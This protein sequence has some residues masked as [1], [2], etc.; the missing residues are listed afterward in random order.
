M[1]A[2]PELVRLELLRRLR[3][4]VAFVTWTA[5][6][7]LMVGLLA[8]V[9]G[10][11]S[12][13]LPRARL[14][15]VDHDSSLASGFLVSAL[16]N[17]RLESL[18]EVS[19]V[20]EAAG[21]RQ[22]DRGRAEALLVVPAGFG[23]DFLGNRPVRLEVFRNPAESILPGVAEEVVAF[24]ADAGTS[25]RAVLVELTG[26]AQLF[27]RQ[28]TMAEVTALAGKIY[29]LLDDPSSRRLVDPATLTVSQHHPAAKA[30]TRSGVVGWFAPGFVVMALLF[31]AQGQ[32]SEVQEDA[33]A[34]RLR[35]AFSYPTP[36]T[37]VLL[38][39]AI[40]LVVVGVS[41]G[42]LLAAVM[43]AALGWRPASPLAVTATVV[44]AVAALVGLSL[45]LR[46]ATSE[47]AAGNAATAG[48]MVGLGFLGGCFVPV[49]LLPPAFQTAAKAL[50]TG[51]AVDALRAA[52]GSADLGPGGLAWRLGALAVCAAVCLALAIRLEVRKAVAR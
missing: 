45:L 9:F 43:V 41:N 23:A 8:A 1:A 6:P 2:L 14:L 26:Q 28:P 18:L 24:L 39:K 50:P 13:G 10:P 5:I 48:V 20:D 19:T 36:P 47:L 42:A 51:W 21:K 30:V 17:P 46:G 37:T 11:S 27:G 52:Q 49:Q 33:A 16:S 3:D 22:M 44:V 29:A 15:V 32:S 31:L 4:P 38:A 34:G 12:T 7:L 40:S 35:R 25:A